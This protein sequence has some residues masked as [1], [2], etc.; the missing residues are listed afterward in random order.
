MGAFTAMAS[1]ANDV[2]YL[3]HVIVYL[4]RYGQ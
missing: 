3:V 1:Y 4:A 2:H